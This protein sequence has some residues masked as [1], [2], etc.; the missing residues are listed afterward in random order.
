M[1]DND[2]AMASL[3]HPRRGSK[4][5]MKINNQRRMGG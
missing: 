5:I 4:A 2:I 3:A 1:T